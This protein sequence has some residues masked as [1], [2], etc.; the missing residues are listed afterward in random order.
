MK[1]FVTVFVLIVTLLFTSAAWVVASRVDSDNRHRTLVS[2]S[3]AILARLDGQFSQVVKLLTT[4]QRVFANYVEVIPDVFELYVAIPWENTPGIRAVGFAPKLTY[5]QLP[6]YVAYARQVITPVFRIAPEG[7]RDVYY[8][9]ENVVPSPSNTRLIGWDL[10]SDEDLGASIN[11]AVSSRKAVLSKPVRLAIEG[12][13]SVIGVIP[14]YPARKDSSAK[15]TGISGVCFV[16]IDLAALIR[17]ALVFS[18]DSSRISFVILDPDSDGSTG[19]LHR[20]GAASDGGD[21]YTG[22]LK[23]ADKRWQVEFRAG[24]AFDGDS[25]EDL[26]GMILVGGLLFSL[27]STAAAFV[28]VRRIP[29]GTRNPGVDNQS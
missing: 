28:L 20:A 6:E 10:S 2:E 25:G 11:S 15:P 12:D 16:Q 9:V 21:V 1:T 3:K 17:A 5:T 4:L 24:S 18:Y 27:L 13:T 26:Q 19:V 7:R 22:T 29:F 14:V 23:I 8:P